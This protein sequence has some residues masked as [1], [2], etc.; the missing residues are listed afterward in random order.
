MLSEE[1]LW[2]YVE[3]ELAPVQAGEIEE[4]ERTDETVRR[5]LDD[6]RAVRQEMLAGAPTPPDDFPDRVALLAARLP[7]A[8]VIHLDEVRRFLRKAL[9]AAAILAAVGLAYLAFEVAPD[10]LEPAPMQA[11]PLLGD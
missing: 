10:W 8:P 3:G 11:S 5:R 7:K 9:V 1:M 2:K 4:L 6:I